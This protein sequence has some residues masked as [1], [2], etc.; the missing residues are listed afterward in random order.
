MVR[1]ISASEYELVPV[2]A[3]HC[4]VNLVL[5]Q[6]PLFI[7][8]GHVIPLAA[9]AEYVEAIDETVFTLIGWM[10]SDTEART[11]LYRDNGFTT[12]PSLEEG[13]TEIRVVADGDTV[14]CQADKITLDASGILVDA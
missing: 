2:P 1:F 3:G 6:F 9:S 4:Y 11:M 5:N 7:R 13:L 14:K 8:K 10:D 12:S